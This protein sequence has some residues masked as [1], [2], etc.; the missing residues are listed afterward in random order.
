MRF[1]RF[2]ER[3]LTFLALR[4]VAIIKAFVLQA[5]VGIFLVCLKFSFRKTI[6]VCRPVNSKQ[7]E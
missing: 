4:V 3:D 6:Q 1:E 5:K 2:G 7:G